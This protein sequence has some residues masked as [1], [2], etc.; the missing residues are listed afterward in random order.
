MME[1]AVPPGVRF[2]KENEPIPVFNELSLVSFVD[3]TCPYAAPDSNA[4]A[5]V[6]F[7][8]VFIGFSWIVIGSCCV[9]DRSRSQPVAG[10]SAAFYALDRCRPPA[11]VRDRQLPGRSVQ[12]DCLAAA[13][14]AF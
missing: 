2:S 4:I 13:S 10:E 5:I 12:F 7:D 6:H 8:I 9:T 14:R 3:G 11:E 1:Q